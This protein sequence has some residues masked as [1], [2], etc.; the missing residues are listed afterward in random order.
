MEDPKNVYSEE[1][2]ERVQDSSDDDQH[3][4]SEHTAYFHHPSHQNLPADQVKID[5]FTAL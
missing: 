4:N 1:E 3:K 2:S 5:N